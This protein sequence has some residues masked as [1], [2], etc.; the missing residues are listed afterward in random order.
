MLLGGALGGWLGVQ[1]HAKLEGRTYKSLDQRRE[2]S[3]A[4]AGGAA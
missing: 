4:R 1:W 2:P 3:G